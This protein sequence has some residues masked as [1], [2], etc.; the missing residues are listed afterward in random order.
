MSGLDKL[1]QFQANK[2]TIKN[3]KTTEEILKAQQ[4]SQDAEWQFKQHLIETINWQNSVIQ[5]LDRRITAL[6]KS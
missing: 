6:E 2:A 5:D 4:A 1:H 3:A